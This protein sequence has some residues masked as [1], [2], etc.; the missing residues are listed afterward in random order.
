MSTP[1]IQAKLEALD[2]FLEVWTADVLLE[3]IA[4]QLTCTEADALD[5]LLRA[6]G[7]YAAAESLISSHAEGDDEGDQHFRGDA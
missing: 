2:T 5:N 6:S 7:Q 4:T 3:D 1:P